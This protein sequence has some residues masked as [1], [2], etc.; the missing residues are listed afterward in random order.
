MSGSGINTSREMLGRNR[1]ELVH[2]ASCGALVDNPPWLDNLSDDWVPVP[3]PVPVPGTPTSPAPSRS[4]SHSRQ[5][6][7]HSLHSVH[8][9]QNSPSRIPV[10][11]RRSVGPSPSPAEQKKVSRPCHFVRRE[12]VKPKTRTPKT[13]SK[14]R[15]PAPDKTPRSPRPSP[16]PKPRSIPPSR[17]KQPPAMD[18]RSPLRSV[19]NVSAQSAQSAQSVQQ[20]T[21]QVRPKKGKGTEGT[22]EWRRRLMQGEIAAGEQRDL[23]API[24]LESVFKPPTPGTEKTQDEALSRLK[25]S[26][27]LW[28]FP[29][30]PERRDSENND[31]DDNAH[32]RNPSTE[33]Q[34]AP[35]EAIDESSPQSPK[36]P[37]KSLQINLEDFGESPRGSRNGTLDIG[38]GPKKPTLN[39]GDAH[40]DSWDGSQM[41]TA[42]GLEDLR[43]EDI[44]P[45][46]FSQPNTVD[47]NA[48]SE[49]IRSALKKVTTK[50]ERLHL[51]PWERPGSRASDSVLL[52]PPS[53]PPVDPLPEDDLLDVTSHSLPKDLSMGTLD[54]RGRGAFTNLRRDEYLNEG[55]FQKLHLS[56][57]SFPSDRLSPFAPSNQRIRSSPPFYQKANPLTDPPTLP[58]PSSAHAGASRFLQPGTDRAEIMPS[59]GSPLKLFGPH[60]TFTNN[61]LMRRMSQFEETFGGLSEDDEPESPS[62][63]ARRKGENRSF[64]SAKQDTLGEPS[65]RRYERPRSRNT[66]N[67]QMN[68]FGDGQ[69]DH[70]DFSDTSPY[71]PK[72]L[73]HD[74]LDPNQHSSSRRLSVERRY[75][76][77]RSYRNH[78]LDTETNRS[79][80]NSRSA[81]VSDMP[82][83]ASAVRR[84]QGFRGPEDF[85]QSDNG[86]RPNSP[87][88]DPHPKRRRTIFKSH[89]LI[90]EDNGNAKFPGQLAD[91][92]SLLQKSLMQQGVTYDESLLQSLSAYRPNTPT[93][94]QARS[95]SRKRPSSSR[96]YTRAGYDDSG[97]QNSPPEHAI[98]SVRVN[99]VSTEIRKGS[100]T[101][102]DFL[103]EATK[104]MDII[105]SKGR[106]AGGLS[107]VE[108]SDAENPD[109]SGSYEDESTREEFSRPPSRE[110]PD[111]RKLREPK[112][113]NPQIA[114]HLR[115]FQED[116]DQE[117]GVNNSVMSLNL[118]EDEARSEGNNSVW[119][120][121]GLDEMDEEQDR[122]VDAE[123]KLSQPTDDGEEDDDLPDLLTINTHIS[124]KSLS[125]RSIPTGSSQS[126]H[127]KGVLSSD[128]VSH[129]IPE[130]VNG[131]TYDR[132]RNQWVKEGPKQSPGRPKGE[133]SE[134]D[135]FKDIPDLSV[136][137]LQ[138]MMRMQS[139][140]SPERARDSVQGQDGA[141]QGSPSPR[142]AF[143][144]SERRPQEK[145]RDPSANFSSLQSKATPFTS[146]L[147]NPETRATSWGTVDRKTSKSTSEVEHEIQLHEGRMS[148][149]PRRQQ[150]NRQQARVV[151][152]SFSSPLV[153]QITYAD[154]ESPTKLR[155]NQGRK[156]DCG[157]ATAEE[158][159]SSRS[160]ASLLPGRQPSA[161]ASPFNLHAIPSIDEKGED[162]AHAMSLVR[163]GPGSATSTPDKSNANNSLVYFQNLGQDTTYSFHLSPL[164]DF[165]VDQID[166]TLHLEVSY[167]AQRT[168]PT[169]LRQ[170]HGT[171]ALATE[172]L[173]KQ[174]TEVEPFEPYWDQIRRLVLRHRGLITL[175][176]LC[177]F[178]PR[179]EEL[180][181]TGNDIGQLSGVPP[182]LRTL[183]IQDNCLSNL[184]A[185]GHLVNLQ[186]LDVSGNG[187]ESLDGFSSLIHLRELKANDNNIRNIDGIFD[188]NGLLS[189]E[190]RNNGLTTVDFAKADLTRLQDLDLSHNELASVY[191]IDLLP[192]LSAL[193]LSFNQLNELETTVS[194]L[195]LRSLKLSNNIFRMLNVSAFPSLNLLYVD[196]NFLGTVSGLEQCHCLEVFSAREQM[197]SG[198][199]SGF[200]DVDLGLVK[201]L[202]KAF[203]SSNKLSLQSLSP[204][205]PL[206]G[207]Q[208]LDI[209]SCSLQGLPA[210]FASSFPN[211]V[212]LNLNFNSLTGVGELAGLKCLSRLTAAGNKITRLR[213]LCQVL[214]RIGR[215]NKGKVCS[216][217]KVDIRGNPLTVRF[218][219]PAVIGNGKANTKKLKGKEELGLRHTLSLDIPSA[220][221]EFKHNGD[222]TH[223]HALGDDEPLSPTKE[224][225]VNDPYTLPPADPLADQKYLSHLDEPTRL[226][227]RIFE[228]MLYAGTGG[229][230]R[231]LDGLELRPS[232][233][234]GSDMDHAWAKLEKLGVLKRK[235]ITA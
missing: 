153:S 178:C 103:N 231:L 73:N 211:M 98:P 173:V 3:M 27:S 123:R 71:E 74:A 224:V 226:R 216:L 85:Y 23:F 34:R 72:L 67:P 190:L 127:A 197:A 152:I 24:G 33:I 82:S 16:S 191:N 9:V 119:D 129:L 204:S 115:K 154:D 112:E 35:P 186:Y 223:P 97:E 53:E 141:Q 65:A 22:P 37:P 180:D 179:L 165:T 108:E 75:L 83:S 160:Q 116:D 234:E 114:N 41:R 201:D 221:A 235:A 183:N 94:S 219:P 213:R 135:P 93:P 61:R 42:S 80:K 139:S 55:S 163:Q 30:S 7:L 11:A 148:K 12:P 113:P 14:L 225:E 210:D 2:I 177:D 158:G 111:M 138:E 45:I 162:S 19:S 100:I 168:Q 54:F 39:W 171:F 38:K 77:R 107:S 233:D 137:E 193:D 134:D 132:D 126:S 120:G 156:F 182:S 104:I 81:G 185:W 91:N 170:V 26:D 217:R 140:L 218:Y 15:S 155:Q 58:R 189:L 20:S 130:Q 122:N 78:S 174:I 146:K 196:Q 206:L 207:L 110:G 147:S 101:T 68:K 4:I 169:S 202:R 13:P 28:N 47:G 99:G 96:N 92:M 25:Q 142:N 29:T 10:P 198:D 125:A 17:R 63:E 209:A 46:T 145:E 105:R 52:N 90:Q 121:A 43:N 200:F 32:A 176:K 230:I 50:L 87:V 62:E 232:I 220:L 215:S 18:T 57:P 199:T 48:T 84:S 144:Q 60:D 205:A 192:A 86:S 149:P 187:L 128:I 40:D 124:A 150:D 5:S 31:N 203:L 51:T 167:V 222:M 79:T 157:P 106:S 184:T 164:P 133:E 56:P 151:T 229:S 159:S 49:V 1:T 208:L 109:E 69:L 228:L 89:S 181:V 172:D 136:D 21:V 102:Q 161:H 212:V 143:S 175:H 36:S 88:K 194:L 118:D 6:S 95:L 70:F 76:R 8:S 66:A 188:L 64:L 214:S 44:T 59:S 117:F 227:R 166:Q 195:G 131:L